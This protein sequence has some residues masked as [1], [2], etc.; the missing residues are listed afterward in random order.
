MDLCSWNSQ[1]SKWLSVC[2]TAT[3]HDRRIYLYGIE[4]KWLLNKETSTRGGENMRLEEMDFVPREWSVFMNRWW[5]MAS[6]R[7]APL[8]LGSIYCSYKCRLNYIYLFIISRL[9]FALLC[10]LFIILTLSCTFSEV[11]ILTPWRRVLL[12]KLRGFSQE[13]PRILGNRKI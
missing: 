2:R 4:W 9:T 7:L 8:S 6:S 10:L 5:V 11:K 3:W 1:H 12:E 13:F